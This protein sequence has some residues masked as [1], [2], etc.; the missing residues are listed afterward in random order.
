MK[1]TRLI[2]SIFTATLVLFACD[3][4]GQEPVQEPT[5][6]NKDNTSQQQTTPED[7]AVHKLEGTA[8]SG[9][10]RWKGLDLGEAFVITKVAYTP[11][12]GANVQLAI[13]EGANSSDFSDA[14][15]LAIIKENSIA[16]KEHEIEVTC[17]RAFR[18][19]RFMSPANANYNLVDLAFWGRKVKGDDSQFYQLTNLPTVIINTQNSKEVTSKT[20]YIG[21]NIYVISDDGKKLLTGLQSKIRGRG[22]ASWG[23]PKKPY[24]IKFAEKQRV[25]G[26]PSSDKSWTL[27]SN[28]GDKTLMR[29]ILAF[30]VSRRVGMA[31]TPFC[32]PVDVVMNGEYEGCYQ[33]CDQVEVGTGRPAQ[34]H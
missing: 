12:N 32:T 10:S 25:L 2:L 34:F 27:I 16:G 28:H 30:E 24:R 21:C 26:S 8:L 33:L 9:T 7:T 3:K 18:Y 5:P 6:D 14:L 19:V 22:N 20:D 13:I 4:V 1:K 29:N 15:P 23:F 31:Y 17:S 11:K